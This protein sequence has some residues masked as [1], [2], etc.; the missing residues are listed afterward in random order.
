MPVAEVICTLSRYK[1]DTIHSCLIC[2][3]NLLMSHHGFFSPS[4]EILL[5][6]LITSPELLTC[7]SLRWLYFLPEG[8]QETINIYFMWCSSKFQLWGAMGEGAVKRSHLVGSNTVLLNNNGV[9]AIYPW[10]SHVLI[11]DRGLGWGER[12]FSPCCT[13]SF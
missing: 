8:T 3:Q 6:Y 12:Y 1:S 4:N 2:C 7:K 9:A 10:N 11:E 5:L 13:A